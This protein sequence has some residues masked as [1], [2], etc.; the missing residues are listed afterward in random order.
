[1]LVNWNMMLL[2][3]DLYGVIRNTTCFKEK[4]ALFRIVDNFVKEN[5]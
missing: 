4:L 3:T 1:M 2:K 5:S